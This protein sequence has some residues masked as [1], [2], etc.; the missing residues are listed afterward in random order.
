MSSAPFAITERCG[1]VRDWASDIA[2][3]DKYLTVIRSN[4]RKNLR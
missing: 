1:A 2:N 4:A 3:R